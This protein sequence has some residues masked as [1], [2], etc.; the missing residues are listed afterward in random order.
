MS[1]PAATTVRV[2]VNIDVP[3]LA[4][5]IAFYEQAIGAKLQRLLDDD[6]AELAYG[7]S[8]LY[9]LRKPTKS[10]ATPTGGLREPGRHWT[11]VHVDF[12]VDD[13]DAAVARALRAGA[14]RESARID[15]RGAKCV[16]FA[17]P[18]GHG[19]CLIEFSGD[20]YE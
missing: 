17:D 9:L 14:V 16:T 15:W 5:A 10:V 7:A 1:G 20:G 2:V 4:P 18:F 19:F 8:L 13:I 3:E 6:V 11:P 12:V